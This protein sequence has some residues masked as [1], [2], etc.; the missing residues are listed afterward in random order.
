[1]PATFDVIVI[2]SGFGGAIT[3]CRLAQ[4]GFKVLILE[5]GR[6]WD[7]RKFPREPL[8][9]WRFDPEEPHLFN[10]WLDF[11]ILHKMMVAQ[12]AGV[13]G[14]SLIYANVSMEAKREIFDSGWPPEISYQELKPYYDRVGSMLKV[15]TIPKN[16]L[17]PHNKLIR[18]AADNCG[19][20]NRFLPLE[21]AITFNPE[22]NYDLPDPFNDDKSKK[23]T[24]DQGQSQGTC[25]HC[26]N[27]DVGCQVSAKNTLNLNYIPLAEQ[28][29]AEVRPLHMVRKIEPQNGG[30][31][32]YFDRLDNEDRVPGQETARRVIVAGGTLNSTELLLRCR[33]EFKT[34]P[35]ISS[36]LGNS[37]SSNADFISAS[38]DHHREIEPTRGP[39][40]TA[41]IDFFDG[42]VDSQKFFIEDGGF[43]NFIG[44][45]LER[46]IG[47]ERSR[48]RKAMDK[49]VVDVLARLARSRDPAS[50]DMLW[51]AVGVDAAN[52]CLYLGRKFFM[53]W[54]RVLKLDWHIDHSRAVIDA[55]AKLHKRLA[56]ATGG[57]SVIPPTWTYLMNL[58]TA[59]PLGGCRMGTNPGNGVVNHRGEVFG[60]SG[61]Y[62][63]DGSIVPKAIG[64]NPSKTIGALAERIADLLDK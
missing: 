55:E 3:G 46:E 45:F 39:T 17:S 56:E 11:R 50:D 49:E 16:Q 4:K 42:S 60:Y 27:C 21:L 2:G 48:I 38:F 40:I 59:H 13:G 5:R 58:V 53:P 23:F 7:P 28:H 31:R 20:G 25:V 43:P 52:G 19:Y 34:L 24:N 1:M 61:L 26:G 51:F 47:S 62:V 36:T 22:W 57:I 12:G 35:C 6:R 32:V 15:Q 64:I 44:N 54:K 30:Y 8:D 63:A 10:G 9:P 18:D 14:G 33:D 41:A 29:G 37:F